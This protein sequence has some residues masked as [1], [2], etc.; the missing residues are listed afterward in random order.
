[1]IDI[2]K[3]S[4]VYFFEKHGVKTVERVGN[5]KIWKNT[6]ES[7]SYAPVSFSNS[8]LDYQNAYWTGNS[9]YYYDISVII[10]HNSTPCGLWPVSISKNKDHIK[11]GSFGSILSSPILVPHLAQRTQKAIFKACTAVAR[12]IASEL[13]LSKYESDIPFTNE[14]G[15]NLWYEIELEN[16]SQTTVIHDLF[17]DLKPEIEKI[18]NGFRKSYKSLITQGQ[19]L[20]NIKL[21]KTEDYPVWNEYKN[22]HL[23]VSG[24]KTR[25]DIS[26]DKQ[27]EAIKNGDAFLVY[28]TDQKGVM[29]GGGLFYTTKNEGLYCVGVYDRK[30]FDYPLGHT[31]QFSAIQELK[32]RGIQW[33]KIGYYP[34]M[35]EIPKPSEKD[36]SIAHFKK[37]F[38]SHLVPKLKIS[39]T[40]IVK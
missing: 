39:H 12:D 9:D 29:V 26:W 38:S 36:F 22:L 7:L 31:V 17:L 5:E 15:S 30:L 35:N 11:F 23:S 20:W 6:L 18:K 21:L 10:Y 33:Y 13:D 14:V 19:K 34:T 8:Y 28:I 25:S 40:T 1:M 37:G 4:I 32:I 3:E 16:G 27:L 2:E 24:K